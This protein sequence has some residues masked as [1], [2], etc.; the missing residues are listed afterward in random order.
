[1][2][3]RRLLAL[4]VVV[5]VV[6]VAAVAVAPGTA[7]S[8]LDALADDPAALV[9]ALTLLAVVRPF[10]AWPTTLLSAV[11]GYGLGLPG[12]VPAVGLLTLTSLPPYLL[13]ASGRAELL[14]GDGRISTAVARVDA[15]GDRALSVAGPFRS[16]VVAR[17]APLPSDVIS[18]A[19]GVAGVPFWPYLAGTA[20]GELP[21]AVGA[22]VAGASLHRLAVSGVAAAFDPRLVAAAAVAGLLLAAAPAYRHYR[23]DT[24]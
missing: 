5:G 11:A 12:V 15:A 13:G 7:L 9:V 8:R 16:T 6:A 1:M 23:G 3:R 22:V 2:S 19:A 24:A 17:L 21:W 10:L 4:G 14:A 20:V 18:G